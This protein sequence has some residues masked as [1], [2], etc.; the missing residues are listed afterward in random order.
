MAFAVAGTGLKTN[1]PCSG[2]QSGTKGWP[3]RK[4]VVVE[5]GRRSWTKK[6]E[7]KQQKILK[8][9]WKPPKKI[10]RCPKYCRLLA[11]PR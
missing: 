4:V 9:I 3:A 10:E 5:R 6:G 11:R 8:T 7:K 2:K 1:G